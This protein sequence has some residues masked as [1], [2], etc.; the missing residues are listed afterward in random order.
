MDLAVESTLRV[1]HYHP[2]DFVR[3]LLPEFV[4]LEL[5]PK[6]TWV[7]EEDGMIKAALLAA[8]GSQTACFLRLAATS[9]A[10][11]NW[12]VSLLR[13][14]IRDL[15]EMNA[16]VIMVC[17]SAE[18]WQELKLLRLIQRAGGIMNPL[19][20]YIVAIPVEQARRW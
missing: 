14:V 3:H 1:R 2:S 6:L 11:H 19:A 16:K 20:G 13:A 18:R 12:M 4:S 8:Y 9:D 5:D 15:E 10:P 7:V 17:L